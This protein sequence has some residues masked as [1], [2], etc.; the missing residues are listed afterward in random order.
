MAEPVRPLPKPDPISLPFWE[1]VRAHAMKLQR[2]SSCARFVFYPRGA[3]PHCGAVALAWTAVSG[4][5]TVH[6]FAIPARHPNP[7]F[8]SGPYVVALI[9]LE[10]GVRMLSNLVGVEPVPSAVHVGMPVEVVYEDVNAEISL[11]KFRPSSG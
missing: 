4:R 11:A 5:G 6:A 10:E 8:G 1:S 7:A 2:C 9:D 3:C